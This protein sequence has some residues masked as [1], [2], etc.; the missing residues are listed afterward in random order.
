MIT[1][2]YIIKILE[3]I[4]G[5]VDKE[6]LVMLHILNSPDMKIQTGAIIL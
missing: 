6:M 4:I 1:V 5:S 3:D 2:V